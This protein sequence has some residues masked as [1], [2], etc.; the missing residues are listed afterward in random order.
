MLACRRA[1]AFVI[2][3][4]NQDEVSY[5]SSWSG[6]IANAMLL[7]V[8]LLLYVVFYVI[9]IISV[10]RCKDYNSFIICSIAAFTCGMSSLMVKSTTSASTSK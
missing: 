8:H 4:S 1:F 6:Q 9:S 7:I 5:V 3:K 2:R 10:S